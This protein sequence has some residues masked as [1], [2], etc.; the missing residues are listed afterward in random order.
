MKLRSLTSSVVCGCCVVSAAAEPTIE[1]LPAGYILTDLAIGGTVGVGNV[2]GD[3]SYETFLWAPLPS[4]RNEVMRLGL[5]TAPVIGVGAGTPDIS[6]DG[7]RVS[8]SILSSD[9]R[10]TQGIWS[11]SGWTETMPPLPP[12]GVLLDQ[13]YGSAWGLSG[14]G[15]AVTG[16][17]WGVVDEYTR[18]RPSQ[19]SPTSGMIGL[20]NS[21]ERSARVNAADYDGSV[22]VGWEEGPGGVWRPTAWRNG[23]KLLVQDTPAFC[24]GMGVNFDGSVIVG[25]TW[26]GA[27]SLREAAVWAWNGVS[28][29]LQFHGALSGTIPNL[30]FAYLE[31]VSDD[32]SIAVGSNSYL[33]VP[34]SPRDGLVWTSGGG[35]VRAS[36]Y[37]A[38][39]GL[40]SQFPD[41]MLITDMVAVSP[42]GSA[43]TGIGMLTSGEFQSFVI[44]LALPPCFGDADGNRNANFDDILTILANFGARVPVFTSGDANGNTS[45]DFDDILA[46]LANFNSDCSP[47]Q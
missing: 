37:I 16:F 33:H 43:M 3:Y 10:M 30:G 29:E 25:M 45:V 17:H 22:V 11:S 27:T 26:D 21:A 1:F 38:A 14:D 44:H 15:Q 23:T 35:L 32:G 8:A 20:P 28:Y 36:D 5:A 41:G 40:S 31:S 18:A 42:D 12:N 34:S 6:Y 9:N 7:T 46:V 39:L 13:S 4:A 24:E 2:S 19:W 47:A